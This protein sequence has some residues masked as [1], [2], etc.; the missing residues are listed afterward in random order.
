MSASTNFPR[1]T[2]DNGHATDHYHALKS[3]V[4]DRLGHDRRCAI[5]APKIARE[6]GWRSRQTLEEGLRETARWYPE[7]RE[8]CSQIQEARYN[9]QRLGVTS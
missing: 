6:L 7:H 1:A 8:W 2:E 9:R 4:P 3:F 5:D